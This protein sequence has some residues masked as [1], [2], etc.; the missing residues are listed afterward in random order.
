MKLGRKF[1]YLLILIWYYTLVV[2]Y[3]I[4]LGFA[5]VLESVFIVTLVSYGWILLTT[6]KLG[7]Y[8]MMDYKDLAI[9]VF[10]YAFSSFYITLMTIVFS[11]EPFDTLKIFLMLMPTGVWTF[12]WADFYI[13]KTGMSA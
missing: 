11:P 3:S 12:I 7:A 9:N 8:E 1:G 5:D 4:E 13:H 2:V 6:R 10:L